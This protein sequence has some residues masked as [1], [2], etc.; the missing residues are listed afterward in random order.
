MNSLEHRATWSLSLIYAF[1][2]LG[3][4]MILPVFT[5]YAQTLNGTT[6]TL[7]GLSF[8]IYGLTQA[9]FQ[10]PFGMLSDKV[11]RKPIIATGLVL[12]AIGSVIAAF[13]DSIWGVT[14]GRALQGAGA[15]GSP[16]LA[17]LADLTRDKVRTRA[18]AAIGIIIGLS[19]SSALVLGPIVNAFAG[20]SA[21]FW[22]TA[23]LAASGLIL[24]Y[25]LV[26]NP[27]LAIAARDIVPA[28]PQ[29]ISL[30]KN[31]ELARLNI[32]IFCLHAILIAIFSV[33]PFLLVRYGKLPEVQQWELY[34]P[35]LLLSFVIAIPTIIIA[36][37][38]HQIKA[39]LLGCVVM[40][41]LSVLGMLIV[42]HSKL[43][44]AAMLLFF[45]ASFT[46]LEAILPSLV[47]KIAPAGA[48]GTATGI[49]S[50][51]Q[52]FGIFVGGVIGGWLYGLQLFNSIFVFSIL[53]GIA[54]LCFAISMAKPRHLKHITLDINPFMDGNLE[55][56]LRSVTG[57][58]EVYLGRDE[59]HI[60]IKYDPGLITEDNIK[61]ELYNIGVDNGTRN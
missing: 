2:M 4:F 9:T 10:I 25:F 3:L 29:F 44:L 43:G 49:Y 45:L 11:G 35:V 17:L 31:I 41:I 52:F 21:I 58:V 1:R 33:V 47:S 32:G 53:I 16:V 7:I 8:G 50:S 18:M 24:L 56:R 38:M 15:I 60:Y 54:W 28:V 26:P 46:A 23:I 57:I 61:A 37:K 48:V 34:L 12:L 19:F 27:E 30:L 22:F 6:A 59:N 40:L 51:A 36:E 14:I 20:V 39:A 13:S 5:M 42:Q 55:A